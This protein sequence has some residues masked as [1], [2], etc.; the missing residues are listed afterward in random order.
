MKLYFDTAKLQELAKANR[1]KYQN[2]DP[3]PH[4]Y[5]DNFMD[6]EPL[7]RVL[8]EFPDPKKKIWREYEN[9][10]EGK[11]EA[12]GEEKISEFTSQLLYQFNSAPFLF[13]L[14]TL[15][16]IQGLIPDPYFL[17]GGLHQ[18][19]PGGKLGIH[20][21][22]NEHGKIKGL[23]R[24]INAI[25]YLN[26]DW[27]EE[28]N[29]YLELW[30]ND[31]TKCVQKIAPIFNRIVIFEVTDFNNHGVPDVL[32]CPEDM[33]RRSIGLFYFTVGR[34]DGQ[35]IE[36]KSSTL[37]KARP[38]DAVPEGTVYDR[39]SYNGLKIDKSFN[40]YVGRVLPPFIADMFRKK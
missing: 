11:L 18:L 35:V 23:S 39:D 5:F 30:D 7:D 38:G 10:F 2:A 3:F 6:P 16:G 25:V 31:M 22:F 13:F 28:Y 8:A 20:A 34:P 9:Y 32:M 33:A 15:S 12:Q 24:R 19:G 40:Y 37:F 26:K 29:G 4:I 36:G 17:G 27:K 1:V 14:E 21:D